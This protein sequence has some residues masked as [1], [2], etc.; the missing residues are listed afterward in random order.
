MPS[1][2]FVLGLKCR[3]CG[4]LY[5]KAASFFCPDDSGPLEVAYDYDTIKPH[6]SRAKFAARPFVVSG[7]TKTVKS[8]VT[9]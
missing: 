7:G 8:F 5:P 2:D 9:P 3:V 6:V 4:K 1:S